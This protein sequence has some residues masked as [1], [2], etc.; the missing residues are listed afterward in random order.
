MF[1]LPLGVAKGRRGR[2]HAA[3]KHPGHLG[4]LRLVLF[5][6]GGFQTCG[7]R[8]YHDAIF[9]TLFS[10]GLDSNVSYDSLFSMG[11]FEK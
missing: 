9:H 8:N 1:R 4:K 11:T 6:G 2:F 10:G 7:R 5:M 3:F